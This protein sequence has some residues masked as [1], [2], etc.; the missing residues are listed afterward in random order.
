MV[1]AQKALL[2]RVL[3]FEQVGVRRDKKSWR[4]KKNKSTFVMCPM[5]VKIG[6]HHIKLLANISFIKQLNLHLWSPIIFYNYTRTR[7]FW[8][9][10][11]ETYKWKCIDL[12]HKNIGYTLTVWDGFFFFFFAFEFKQRSE[13]IA[14]QAEFLFACPR[15]IWTLIQARKNVKPIEQHAERFAEFYYPLNGEI[16]AFKFLEISLTDYA[17]TNSTAT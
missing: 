7:N 2:S 12:W 1:F 8:Y 10:S 14:K 3:R 15:S 5:C 11:K 16:F 9:V 13:S 17:H 4:Q 6:E